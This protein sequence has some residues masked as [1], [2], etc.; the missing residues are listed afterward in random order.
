VQASAPGQVPGDGPHRPRATGHDALQV[1]P[2]P[3]GVVQ[4]VP[5]RAGG[6]SGAADVALVRGL[7]GGQGVEAQLAQGDEALVALLLAVLYLLRRS[8]DRPRH[9]RFVP[10]GGQAP[11]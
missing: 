3:A 2:G 7:L 1:R 8:P 10:V 4:L 6:L 9:R 11:C 5:R